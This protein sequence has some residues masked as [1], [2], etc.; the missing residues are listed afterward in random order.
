[1]LLRLLL[2]PLVVAIDYGT[3][4]PRHFITDRNRGGIT[5]ATKAMGLDAYGW[6]DSFTVNVQFDQD[7]IVRSSVE[8]AIDPRFARTFA[9]Y[10]SVQIWSRDGHLRS[11]DFFCVDSFPTITFRSKQVTQVG[12]DQYRI[13]G[14]L[15]MR[16]VTRPFRVPARIDRSP[17]EGP[18]TVRFF[19]RWFFNRSD[20]GVNGGGGII[21]DRVLVSFDFTLRDPAMWHGDP[22]ALLRPAVPPLRPR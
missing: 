20:F 15:T 4:D 8:I 16:G 17:D 11:C 9:S 12:P 14:D 5:F 7:T 1:M 13:D 6:F 3:P 10:R 18:G 21:D 22:P 19:G 2:L